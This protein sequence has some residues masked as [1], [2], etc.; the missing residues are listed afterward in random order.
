MPVSCLHVMGRRKGE[1]TVVVSF[2][3]EAVTMSEPGP[4]DVAETARSPVDPVTHRLSAEFDEC[5]DLQVKSFPRG[6]EIV[7]D[8]FVSCLLFRACICYWIFPPT[9]VDDL[10][11]T[12][13]SNESNFLEELWKQGG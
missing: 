6:C 1:K 8:W 7:P 11:D 9:A 13:D 3:V 4:G 12:K 2:S 10:C 5:L